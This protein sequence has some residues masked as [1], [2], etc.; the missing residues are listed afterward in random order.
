[1]LFIDR[2]TVIIKD[3]CG[4]RVKRVRID[5]DDVFQAHKLSLTEYN[6]LA[7]DIIKIVDADG[8]EAYTL[9]NGFVY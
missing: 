1:M 9:E 5:A 6:E 4:K 2:F 8:N 3:V 7:Q